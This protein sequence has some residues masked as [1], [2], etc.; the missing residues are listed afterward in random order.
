MRP[1]KINEDRTFHGHIPEIDSGILKEN[2]NKF[3]P[4][5]QNVYRYVSTGA[6]W[7][8]NELNLIGM[9]NSDNKCTHCGEI[10]IDSEHHLWD[11][12]EIN[13][14]RN[15]KDLCEFDHKELPKCVRFGIPPAM[16]AKLDGPFWGKTLHP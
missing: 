13:K 15:F 14:H 4:H 12:H 1:V 11:C 7:N 2:M 6:V 16:D 10:V 8:Q 5:E 9:S 3:C